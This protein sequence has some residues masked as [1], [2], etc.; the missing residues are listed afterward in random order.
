V[1]SSDLYDYCQNI[2]RPI[3]ETDLMFERAQT[4]VEEVSKS[5][6]DKYL[7]DKK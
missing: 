5:L 2:I 7:T 4:R 3:I 1:C 6:K